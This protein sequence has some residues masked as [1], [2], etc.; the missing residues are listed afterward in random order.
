M[1]ARWV[2]SRVARRLRGA[3]RDEFGS[4]EAVL[5]NPVVDVREVVAGQR[6]GL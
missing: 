1:T 2:G 3:H 5:E 6:G 4:P